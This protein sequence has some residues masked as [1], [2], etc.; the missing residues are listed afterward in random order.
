[1]LSEHDPINPFLFPSETNAR[2]LLLIVAIA[3]ITLILADGVIGGVLLTEGYLPALV[4]ALGVTAGVF[5]RARH[6]ARRDA[7]RRIHDRQW[8]AFPPSAEGEKGRSLQ[9]MNRYLLGILEQLPSVQASQPQFVWDEVNE[10]SDRPT[11]IAFGYGQRK[12]IC[13]RQGLYNAF[14]KARQS[15][16]FNAVLLHELGHLENQ[17]VDQTILALTLGKTFFPVALVLLGLLNLHVVGS[18]LKRIAV[19]G[20]LQPVLEGLPTIFSINLKTIVLILLVDILLSSVLRVREYYADARARAWLGQPSAFFEV[21]ATESSQPATASAAPRPLWQQKILSGYHRLTL[22]HPTHQQR[23]TALLDPIEL[24]RPSREV[25]LLSGLL[26]GL[27]LNS[28]VHFIGVGAVELNTLVSRMNQF[29]QGLESSVVTLLLLR[30][31]LTAITLLFLVTFLAIVVLLLGLGVLPVIATVGLQIQAATLS[32]RVTPRAKPYVTRPQLAL[33]ALMLGLGFVLG[34]VLVPVPKTFSLLGVSPIG[35]VGFVMLWAITFGLWL[36][37]LVALAQRLYSNHVG[38]Q[39]P[40]HKRRFLTRLSA[41]ALLPSFLTSTIAHVGFSV[42]TFAPETISIQGLGLILISLMGLG[43]GLQ[44]V[45]WLIGW[46]LANQVGWLRSPQCP[47][48]HVAVTGRISPRATCSACGAALSDWL[49]LP[50][51]ITLPP[52]PTP[53]PVATAAPPL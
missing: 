49:H 5:M 39:N 10:G 34:C 33:L 19:Q 9:A 16:L 21:F 13:L 30:L 36:L 43:F 4:A 40:H 46:G 28:G 2:Y 1:M 51:P 53:E 31:I 11:G 48:C 35:L 17:D 8:Q 14:L 12:Y 37:P 24:Y 41:G 38:E 15:P 18:V 47:Q 27:V 23:I 22:K 3:G 26:S 20:S 7:Q 52:L 42:S 6:L 44:G 29:A 25:A 32:D 50:R 45:I